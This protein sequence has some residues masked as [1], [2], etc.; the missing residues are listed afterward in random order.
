MTIDEDISIVGSFNMDY[1][2]MY[3]DTEL[4]L[5]ID[6]VELNAI[7]KAS[8]ESYEK[9]AVEAEVQDNELGLMLQQKNTNK[10]QLTRVGHLF[11][12]EDK[13]KKGCSY[14]HPSYVR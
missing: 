13:K 12:Y 9:D 5:V 3:H 10:K 8:H 7:L 1:K 14:E 6:S 2:S 4:M 11:L